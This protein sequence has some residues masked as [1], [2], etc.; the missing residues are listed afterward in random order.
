MPRDRETSARN[1]CD[2]MLIL[3][4][5]LFTI[6][7]LILTVFALLRISLN[8]FWVVHYRNA[9]EE[10]DYAPRVL[11][12][13]PCRGIDHDM[14]ENFNSIL[15]Q[16]YQNFELIGVVDSI[17]DPANTVLKKM[18]I[19]TII[20]ENYEGASSG[21]VRAI[22]TAIRKEKD[23]D[24][25]VLAD[26][27]T[28]LPEHW[29]REMVYPLKGDRV[30][31]VTTYPRYIPM[32]GFWSK[33]KEIWGYIGINIMEFKPT[34]F[35]W[36]GSVSFKK[37][38]MDEA[39]LEVFSK[40]VSDDAALTGICHRKKL[41]IE[42]APS[43][44]PKIAV[45]DGKKHFF[46]WAERQMAVSI[47]YNKSALFAGL[48]IYVGVLAY[49]AIV[50]SLTYIGGPFYLIGFVPYAINVISNAMRDWKNS[51]LLIPISFILPIIYLHNIIS[52]AR[53]KEIQWR[54]KNYR[55]K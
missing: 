29:L 45:M 33:V 20:T 34:R 46:D 28:K 8:V 53:S 27:D 38:L 2:S 21:K 30:G 54:G 50:L 47:V 48:F 55:I 25:Y 3:I 24:V 40:S 26:S 6:L 14:E 4:Y 12:I 7:V 23:Y 39:S 52:G 11:V 16:D 13:V 49:I 36:G 43:A 15:Y 18:G 10:M 17:E 9:P 19:R 1:E 37:E 44:S 31:A 42:Y 51:L 5:A 41:N 22:T 32:G 35:I